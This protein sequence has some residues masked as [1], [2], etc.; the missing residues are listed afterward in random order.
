MGHCGSWSAGGSACGL[1]SGGLYTE[2]PWMLLPMLVLFLP[3]TSC[4]FLLPLLCLVASG[5]WTAVAA[6][7]IGFAVGTAAIAVLY[8]P[9]PL[10]KG[11]GGEQRHSCGETLLQHALSIVMLLWTHVHADGIMRQW[12]RACDTKHGPDV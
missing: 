8:I 5:A 3:P 9:C 1:L 7:G 6:S 10:C 2:L 11:G 4:L 12:D